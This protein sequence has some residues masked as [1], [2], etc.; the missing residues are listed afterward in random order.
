M[1]GE[2]IYMNK[3]I[4]PCFTPKEMEELG[5]FSNIA[6][7]NHYN[8][9]TDHKYIDDYLYYKSTGEVLPEY[10][11]ELREAYEK[12]MKDKSD[13]NKQSLLELG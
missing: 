13:I 4:L 7:E 11:L 1:K 3:Q 2:I 5:V 9:V 10:Y 8:V 12:Y 6:E